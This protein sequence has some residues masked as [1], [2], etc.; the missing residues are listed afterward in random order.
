MGGGLKKMMGKLKVRRYGWKRLG[1]VYEKLEGY[2][3]VMREKGV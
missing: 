1:K 2:E 3:V